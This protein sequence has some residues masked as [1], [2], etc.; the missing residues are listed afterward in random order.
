VVNFKAP[1][2]LI[3]QMVDVNI[4]QAMHYSLR[5]EVTLREETFAAS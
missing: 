5:G 3:G 2:R 4:T 1:A